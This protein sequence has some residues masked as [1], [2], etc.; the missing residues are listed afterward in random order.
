MADT[1]DDKKAYTLEEGV[2]RLQDESGYSAA[3]SGPSS[4]VRCSDC[5]ADGLDIVRDITA[6]IPLVALGVA[7]LAGFVTGAAF[8]R[9]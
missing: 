3:S 8:A 7:A 5:V 4:W 6:D 9:R 2:G 1:A